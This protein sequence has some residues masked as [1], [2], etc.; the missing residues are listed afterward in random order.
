[1]EYYDGAQWVELGE[2]ETEAP[3]ERADRTLTVRLE[4]DGVPVPPRSFE[5]FVLARWKTACSLMPGSTN[6]QTP[7]SPTSPAA[8]TG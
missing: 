4:V 5:N 6:S 3:V 7:S 1:L 2:H 8:G